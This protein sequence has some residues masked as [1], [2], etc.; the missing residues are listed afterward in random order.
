MPQKPQTKIAR[1]TMS[2]LTAKCLFSDSDSEDEII[3]V[4]AD[5]TMTPKKQKK[6]D[7]AKFLFRED[8][9]GN[10]KVLKWTLKEYVRE[11]AKYPHLTEFVGMLP[12]DA[13]IIPFVDFYMTWANEDDL[14]SADE[15][16][17][18]FDLVTS[19]FRGL[20][21]NE[22]AKILSATRSNGHYCLK[23]TSGGC[24]KISLRLFA[25]ELVTTRKMLETMLK[26]YMPA[27]DDFPEAL[28]N[29]DFTGSFFDMSVYDKNRKMCCI[30]KTK[31]RE[32]KR[33][34]ERRDPIVEETKY[35]IQN[36]PDDAQ[37]GGMGDRETNFQSQEDSESYHQGGIKRRHRY[38]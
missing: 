15:E 22:N 5:G 34:L 32:D 29:H 26:G 1:A 19:V 35:L 37:E 23:E 30:G 4:A 7:G 38:Y 28:R 9:Y 20:F 8:Y 3:E 12:D 25:P 24:W 27:M 2:K 11:Q 31:W 36:V 14:P 13:K 18:I 21:N 33:V 6:M 16:D 17:E 10:D